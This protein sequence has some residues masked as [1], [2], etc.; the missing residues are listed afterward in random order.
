MHFRPKLMISEDYALS[1][2][3]WLMVI[4]MICTILM[5][6]KCAL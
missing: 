5:V 2:R 1:S 3:K 6:E 4:D